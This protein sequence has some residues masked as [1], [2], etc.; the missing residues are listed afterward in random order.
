MVTFYVSQTAN[1][2]SLT[3]CLYVKFS[4]LLKQKEPNTVFEAIVAKKNSKTVDKASAA[5]VVLIFT[6]HNQVKV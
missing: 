5:P 4:L 1:N 6:Q 3:S 2:I